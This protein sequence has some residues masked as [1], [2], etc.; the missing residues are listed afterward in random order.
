VK[1][2]QGT[3]IL[4]ALLAA[5]ASPAAADGLQAGQW[6]VTSTP[7]INGQLAPPNERLRCMT[8]AEVADLGKTFSPEAN[9]AGATCERAEHELTPTSLKWR[10]TCTGQVSMDVA[11]AFAFESP[12]RY[13]AE[14][15]TRMTMAGQTMQSR[16]TITGERVGECP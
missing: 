3:L 16:V 2:Y 11:G 6:K 8:A 15:R 7:E 10:L 9:T 13:S 5:L 1:R 14:V 4:T 12:Q